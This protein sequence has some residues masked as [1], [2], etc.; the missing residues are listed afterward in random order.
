MGSTQWVMGLLI[1]CQLRNLDPE[2]MGCS[3]GGGGGAFSLPPSP[4][5]TGKGDRGT[6]DK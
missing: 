3:D 6:S 2:K 1:W 4:R 5:T